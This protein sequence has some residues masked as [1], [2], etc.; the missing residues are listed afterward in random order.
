[1]VF[2]AFSLLKIFSGFTFMITVVGKKISKLKEISMHYV[3]SKDFP[4]DLLILISSFLLIF[5]P[6]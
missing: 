4:L 2:V 5:F 3:I 1:M 6:K